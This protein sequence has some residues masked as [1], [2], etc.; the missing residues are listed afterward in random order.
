[1]LYS[2]LCPNKTGLGK[3]Y[4]YPVLRCGWRSGFYLHVPALNLFGS[5][6]NTHHKNIRLS[7]CYIPPS[8]CFSVLREEFGHLKTSLLFLII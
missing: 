4:G 3:L 8:Y 5:M 7:F 6:C 1:M 2:Q